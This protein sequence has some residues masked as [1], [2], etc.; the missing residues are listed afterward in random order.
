MVLVT[1]VK[2]T[3][4]LVAGLAP[5]VEESFHQHWVL[6]LNVVDV[7]VFL[8]QTISHPSDDALYDVKFYL[9]NSCFNV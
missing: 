6:K 4:S 7:T 9:F 8:T 1:T 3:D 2:K 5:V